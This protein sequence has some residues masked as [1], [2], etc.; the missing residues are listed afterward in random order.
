MLGSCTNHNPVQHRDMKPPWCNVCGRM[1]DGQFPKERGRKEESY[2]PPSND[3]LQTFTNQTFFPNDP[4][5]LHIS[6]YDIAHSLAMQCRYNG[7]TKVFYSVAEHSV[8]VSYAVPVEDALWGLLHDAPEAYIG[9]VIRPLK[10]DMP[11]FRELDE[12]IMMSICTKFG[13][14]YEMPESVKVADNRIIANERDILL[15]TPPLPNH[16]IEGGPL[17]GIE[18]EGWLPEKAKKTYFERLQELLAVRR[19]Q[20]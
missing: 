1:A 5:S 18:I 19:E 17:K 7:H 8:L 14:P 13:I 10:K 3:W 16:D 15:G 11:K 4:D 2:N 9:D 20:T 12:R 6:K